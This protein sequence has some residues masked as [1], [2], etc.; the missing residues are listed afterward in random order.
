MLKIPLVG[1]L[2]RP[3]AASPAVL[4][5]E[6]HAA[7]N[8]LARS[9]DELGRRRRDALAWGALLG[10]CA[11]AVGLLGLAWAL[12]SRRPRSAVRRLLR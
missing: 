10:R 11:F 3:E 6:V 7:W 8:R 12:S 9:L 1:A 4:E 2:A 5:Q